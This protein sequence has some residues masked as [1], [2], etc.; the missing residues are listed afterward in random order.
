MSSSNRASSTPHN[1]V[2]SQTSTTNK[3]N[4]FIKKK[5]TVAVI[6]SRP[7]I[8]PYRKHGI[9]YDNPGKFD[10]PE[11]QIT[12]GTAIAIPSAS[13]S[14][15]VAPPTVTSTPFAFDNHTAESQ[16][17]QETSMASSTSGSKRG[18][19]ISSTSN[20][21][22]TILRIKRKRHEEPLDTLVVQEQLDKLSGK[23]QKKI[24]DDI[25]REIEN[26]LS[27][28][29]PKLKSSPAVFRLAT[30]VNKEI[31]KDPTQS[32]QLRDTITHLAESPR[33]KSRQA[34]KRLSEVGKRVTESRANLANTLRGDAKTARYRVINQNRS[35]LTSSKEAPPEVKSS[36]QVEAEAALDMFKMYDAVKEEEP[37]TKKQLQQEAEEAE[38]MCNFLPMVREYLTISDKTEEPQIDTGD[39]PSKNRPLATFSEAD[40][41]ED[42][43]VYDIYYRDV[44]ADH[45]QESKHRGIGSLLWFSDDEGN[46]MNEDDSSDDD[47]EDSDSNA[48]DY[49]QNDYPEDEVSE[50]DLAYELSDSD[51]EYM[52]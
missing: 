16:A 29:D 52:Y 43:Y 17:A 22:L 31:F 1:D 30:T 20:D 9:D 35:G 26:V 39:L 3:P 38:I 48:E 12:P 25:E 13:S 51:D 14:T 11:L 10:P 32:L 6:G 18:A 2:T 5:P 4:L 33:P 36:V 7:L 15:S 21:G 47:Y 40:D 45:Q 49:Y 41:S 19:E 24:E 23:K 34:E 42:E 8:R 27:E 50:D 44:N 46:F 28:K 37:K